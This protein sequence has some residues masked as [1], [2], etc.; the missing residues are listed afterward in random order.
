MGVRRKVT[1]PAVLS[2]PDAPAVYDPAGE[3]IG[4]DESRAHEWHRR[5]GHPSR[6]DAACRAAGCVVLL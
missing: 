6:C 1:A 4:F 3:L 5:N 2:V